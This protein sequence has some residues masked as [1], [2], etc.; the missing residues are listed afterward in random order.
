MPIATKG[1]VGN[2]FAS[3][4]NYRNDEEGFARRGVSVIRSDEEEFDEESGFK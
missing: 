2:T 1:T 4:R 3:A